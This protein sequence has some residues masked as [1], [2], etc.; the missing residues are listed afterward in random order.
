MADIKDCPSLTR[1]SVIAAHELV[2]PYVHYTPVLTNS[3]ITTLASTPQTPKALVGTEWEGRTSVKPK[4]RIWF[5]CENLQRVGA[6]KARGAF[7]AIQRL[8]S[9]EGWE[10]TGGRSKGV[11]THSS[12][13]SFPRHGSHHSKTDFSPTKVTTHKLSL[14]PRALCPSR[15]QS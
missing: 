6:F 7:H 15:Q 3:T 14:S 10:E 12:G 4:I 13:Q 1:S 9:Q 11:I 2:K 8:M 5:K